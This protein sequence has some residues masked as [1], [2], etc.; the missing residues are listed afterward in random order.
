MT[1][2]RVTERD[3]ELAALSAKKK[4]KEK[5]SHMQSFILAPLSQASF[6]FLKIFHYMLH[7]ITFCG[8]FF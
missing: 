6:V 4:K 3:F 1:S 7:T 5:N 8:F 2:E